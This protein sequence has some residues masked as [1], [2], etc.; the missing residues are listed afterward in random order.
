MEPP[1]RSAIVTGGA[2]GI[3]R[4]I[5]ERLARAGW[6]VTV[7]GERKR[8]R[9]VLERGRAAGGPDRT[10]LSSSQLADLDPAAAAAAAA[11]LPG[12]G[13]ARGASLDVRDDG[14]YGRVF[15]AHAA[16]FPGARLAAVFLNAG[17]YETGDVV[18]GDASTWRKPLDVNLTG[19]IAGVRHAARAAAPPPSPPLAVVA[20]AS[21]GGLYPMP[22]APVY[23]ASKGGVVHYVRSAARGLAAARNVRLTALCPE[24]VDTAMVSSASL[25]SNPATA[26][27]GRAL[28]AAYPRLLGAGE[29]AAAAVAL[30]ADASCVGTALMVASSG[31]LYEARRGKGALVDVSERFGVAKT[32]GAAG[33][34]APSPALRAARAAWAAAGDPAA[35]RAAMVVRLTPDFGRA[36]D[37]APSPAPSTPPPG[38]LLVRR[39]YAGVNASDVNFAAGR[40]ARAGAPGV[41]PFAAGFEAVGAVAA[42]GAGVAGWSPGDAVAELSYG[43]FAEYGVV[44]ASRALRIRAPS[45]ETVALLTSGLTAALSLK[46]AL[47]PR[48]GDTV[49]ITAAAGGTGQFAVQL[50]AAAGAR[51]VAVVGSPAKAALA[52]SLGAAAAIDYK[53]TDLATEL[54]KVAPGGVD[55]AWESVG[56]S[57]FDAAVKALKPGGRVVIIGM[58]SAYADE[59]W[60]DVP[61]S[62]ARLPEALLWKGATASGF[63]LLRHAPAFQATLTD[64]EARV[65]AGTL[66]VALDGVAFR[67]VAAVPAA[68]A[69]LQSGASAGKVVVQLS[70]TVPPGVVGDAK[71]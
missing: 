42:V 65:G 34:P 35:T 44:R 2:A 63:F 59:G 40:Y 14:G 5:G 55:A 60:G 66:R 19:V 1:Q 61:S 17:V 68:V 26:A 31:A 15:A 30:A 37:I 57:T 27:A 45:R 39:A 9:G 56:G 50:A 46:L 28:L 29:V 71:L 70:D 20:V 47:K 12:P 69:R 67:G 43:C 23:A 49:L 6:A 58:M 10:P 8:R 53:A 48:P 22:A 21:A 32:G 41:P 11:A 3:G 16:A 4:A 13:P 33:A 18:A 38:H 36:V 64:L 7:R 54:K 24:P 25:A 62:G 51:V 52:R